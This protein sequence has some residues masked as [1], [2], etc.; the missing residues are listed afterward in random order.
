[1]DVVERVR[2]TELLAPGT[3]VV[4]LLSGGRDSTCL[5]GVAV[6]LAGAGGVRAL[7]VNYGLRGEASDADERHCAQLCARLGVPLEVERAARPDG[8]GNLQAWA[9]EVRYAAGA[10]AA[11]GAGARLAA[12][13]TL[14][15]QVETILYRL[16][17]SP[18]RRAL[19][20]MAASSGRLDRPLLAAG[21]TRE[22]T[23]A[24]CRERGVA[25]RDDA[26]NE[27]QKYARVR[28]RV[29]LVPALRAVDP[30]A[31]ANLLRTAELLREEAAVLDEMVAGVLAGRDHLPV[32]ELA[33]LPP[34]LGRLVLRRLAEDAT[35]SSCPRAAAR[36][37]DVLAL[38]AGAL[39]VGDG[40]RVVVERGLVRVR[41]T[42]P[43]EPVG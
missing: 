36:L 32:G 42:P 16:A 28:V 9:R 38:G 40:A 34:A 1:V 43:R 33:A 21:V 19:T 13:H 41:R 29:S 27:D 12:G 26:S 11:A 4:V 20:G 14:D 6:E 3:T 7:H 17:T 30:R 39:D 2:A 24:W 31:E 23:A 25:W 35:G 5:L 15:D 10:R 37:G 18:G 8:A 22:E